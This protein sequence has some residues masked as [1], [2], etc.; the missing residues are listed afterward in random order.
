MLLVAKPA[1]KVPG[2]PSHLL[3]VETKQR[4][5]LGWHSRV[6]INQLLL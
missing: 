3:Q 1:D 6:A 5:L 2:N 4:R